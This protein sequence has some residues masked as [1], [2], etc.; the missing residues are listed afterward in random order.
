MAEAQEVVDRLRDVLTAQDQSV[1]PELRDLAGS[2]AEL[3]RA[4]NERIRRCLQLLRQNLRTEAVHLAEADPNVLDQLAI[5]DF[6]GRADWRQ[7]CLQYGLPE[8]PPLDMDST[9][10]IND[11]Y[12][13]VQPIAVLLAKHR[14]LAMALAPLSLR[15]VVMREIAKL[16]TTA[17]FWADDIRLFEAT[18]LG[19]IRQIL[20][21]G[22]ANHGSLE[23][24][25]GELNSGQWSVPVP[26][27]LIRYVNARVEKFRDREAQQ[28]IQSLLPELD[29][30]YLAMEEDHCR[31]LLAD[32]TVVLRGRSPDGE[33]R[34]RLEAVR[35]WLRGLEQARGQQRDFEAAC[36][37]LEQA[38][39]TG[40]PTEIIG[41]AYKASTRFPLAI[42]PEL[43][44]RYGQ[45]MARRERDATRRRKVIYFTVAAA[46][47]VLLTAIGLFAFFT[48]RSHE[49]RGWDGVIKAA[50]VGVTR[51]GDLADGRKILA[52]LAKQ[53]AGLR[54]TP[55]IAAD[56]ARL[57]TAVV[58]EKARATRFQSLY[59][60]A[61][62]LYLGSGRALRLMSAAR[63]IALRPAEKAAVGTWF[64]RRHAYDQQQQAL[65]DR[66]FNRAAR[67][68][69]DRVDSRLTPGAVRD[70]ALAARRALQ[71][72]EAQLGLLEATKG[73]TQS[74]RNAEITSV[75]AVLSRRSATI[76][77]TISDDVAYGRILAP[78][79]TTGQY[80]TALNDYRRAHPDGRYALIVDG[81][82]AAVPTIR[83]VHAWSEL[84]E[85]WAGGLLNPAREAAKARI[86]AIAQY[87][88]RYAGSP[89]AS[90]AG[91][92]SNYLSS[93]LAATASGGPWLGQFSEVLHNRL[94][95]RLHTLRT[96][97][98]KTY[99]V[100]AGTKPTF[101]TVGVGGK[102]PVTHISFKAVTSADISSQ[103]TIELPRGVSIASDRRSPQAALSR[104]LLHTINIMSLGQWN[105]IGFEEIEILESSTA[106][107]VVRGLLLSDAIALN[108][109]YL[110]ARYSR[111]FADTGRTL[112]ALDL[113]NVNWLDPAGK[114]V[115]GDVIRGVRRAFKRLPNVRAMIVRAREANQS[116]KRRV[117]FN[118]ASLAICRAA[119][120]GLAI[121]CA[122]VL[123]SDN[124][125]TAWVVVERGTK[126]RLEKLG[127]MRSGK[128][129]FAPG[130]AA[131]AV[132]G[133]LVFIRG[134]GK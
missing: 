31:T 5:L 38:I 86:A 118:I 125:D 82:I 115:A 20:A 51:K 65:R 14:M 85:G 41:Q 37:R 96:S 89:F 2:Y 42:P 95:R 79:L 112:A 7:W 22:K 62:G 39:D 40:K 58:M 32:C 117:N 98:G 127:V 67:A 30:A 87:L 122:S 66:A 34:E 4:V 35:A 84:E 107:P 105:S 97:D 23:N 54:T 74:L 121:R 77:N 111:A 120:G 27:D 47:L 108:K 92:Y 13:A 21:S 36:T 104:Q 126:S 19:E 109:P 94:L 123:P 129:N 101:G 110:P 16:D 12:T 80:I 93:A 90:T 73:V 50:T 24:V 71:K 119:P 131:G 102:P 8:A 10:A 68:L 100:L 53:P 46:A 25:Q 44:T 130:A 60:K 18:R 49:A 134:G 114:P 83:A 91:K 116:L 33:V 70:N 113:E 28:K 59:G 75:Q 3:C 29:A 132:E 106:S 17:T 76:S 78:P 55:V 64:R 57:Q 128:W 69:L 103:T 48:I 61:M 1:T 9:A 72:L 56:V 52:L 88:K 45:C 6:S 81:L 43:E 99:F 26:A 63:G 124:G 11:A 15:L 133:T